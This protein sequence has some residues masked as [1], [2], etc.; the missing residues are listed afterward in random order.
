MNSNY[1]EFPNTGFYQTKLTDNELF[2]IKKEIDSIQENFNSS[3]SFN[4]NLAGNL[5]HEY[6]LRDSKQSLEELLVPLIQEYNNTCGI[7]GNYNIMNKSLPLYLD[8]AWVNFQG[9]HEFNPNHNHEGVLSFVIWITGPYNLNEELNTGLGKKSNHNVPGAFEFQY[10]STTGQI[11]KYTIPV[12][13][14]MENSI[15][16]FPASMTHC[17]YPFSLSEDYRISVSGNFKLLA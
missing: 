11:L 12:N 10:T 17:A 9:K 1:K 2:S 16:V 14:E 3:T 13:K 7:L 6:V 5:D 8:T 15:I 4:N